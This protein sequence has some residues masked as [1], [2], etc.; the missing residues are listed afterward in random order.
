LKVGDGHIVW[1]LSE[2]EESNADACRSGFKEMC[3]YRLRVREPIDKAVPYGRSPSSYK[4]FLA[5]ETI[6]ADVQNAD[7]FAVKEKEREKQLFGYFKYTLHEL[8]IGILRESADESFE[9]SM[10]ALDEYE[11]LCEKLCVDRKEFIDECRFYYVAYEDYLS[12][13]R[14]Y[15]GFKDYLKKHEV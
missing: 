4:R 11:A 1:I 10:N 13:V 14:E 7:L 8:P 3:I 15:D 2:T 9:E 12:V 6:E 5:V